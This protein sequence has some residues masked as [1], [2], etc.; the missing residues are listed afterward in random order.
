MLMKIDWSDL[1][2]IME[3]LQSLILLEQEK[4]LNLESISTI[5]PGIDVLKVLE[6][7][8]RRLWPVDSPF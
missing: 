1:E 4:G 8:R 2:E 3:L 5:S 7:A 6:K